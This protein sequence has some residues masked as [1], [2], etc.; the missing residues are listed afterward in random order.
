MP[1]ATLVEVKK[2]FE[3]ESTTTFS[4]EWRALS[5]KDQ[6]EIKEGIGDG[7]LNY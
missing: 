7:S 2:F 1:P 5:T 4:S 6:Q 3:I